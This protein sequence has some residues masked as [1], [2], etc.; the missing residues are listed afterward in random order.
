[1]SHPLP[2]FNPKGAKNFKAY[3]VGFVVSLLLTLASFALMAMHLDTAGHVHLFSKLGL[4][5]ALLVLA[6]LQLF[7]QVTCFLRLN[8]SKDGRWDLMP[9]I[10]TLFVVFIVIGGSVWIMFSL[11]YH[12]MH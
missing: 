6:F 12:M 3:I 1:M 2:E 5:V 4:Y 11:N 7:V 10:F 8:A 9:F